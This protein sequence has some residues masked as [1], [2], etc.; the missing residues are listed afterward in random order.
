MPKYDE[1][2]FKYLQNNNLLSGSDGIIVKNDKWRMS[3]SN[4]EK[5]II[6]LNKDLYRSLKYLNKSSE[7]HIDIPTYYLKEIFC[8]FIVY[9]GI[10]NL[11]L[12][13]ATLALSLVELVKFC[14]TELITSPFYCTKLGSKLEKRC[15]A[16]FRRFK[17]EFADKF[18]SQ[19]DLNIP[20]AVTLA[21]CVAF[22]RHF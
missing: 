6:Q 15:A 1:T 13:R 14:D 22:P 19:C 10:H 3:F 17:E 2:K 5:K 12:E 9:Q 20:A 16:L 4:G 18:E 8:S 7:H 21:S 11:P